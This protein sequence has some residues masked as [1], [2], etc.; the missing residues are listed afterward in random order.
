RGLGP[1]DGPLARAGPH[2][3]RRAARP[4]P[5]PPPLPA[6][7]GDGPPG[8]GLGSDRGGHLARTTDPRPQAGRALERVR[9]AAGSRRPAGGARLMTGL[10][11]DQMTL[12]ALK[13]A[14]AGAVALAF[15]GAP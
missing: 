8:G 3:D 15:G 1:A 5:G 4:R 14:A 6:E 11:T 12:M 2:R 9:R 7:P 13:S 10:L